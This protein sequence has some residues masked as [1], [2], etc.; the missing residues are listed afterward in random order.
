MQQVK[1]LALSLQ[2][3]RCCY[4]LSSIPDAERKEKKKEPFTKCKKINLFKGIHSS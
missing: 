3:F 4:G 2:W 1:D